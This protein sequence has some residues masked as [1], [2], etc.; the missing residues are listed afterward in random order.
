VDF[1]Y[2]NAGWF[3]SPLPRD[4]FLED[5]VSC[6]YPQE[7]AAASNHP[8]KKNGSSDS[9]MTKDGSPASTRCHGAHDLALLF[10]VLAFGMQLEAP[11]A[12]H[13]EDSEVYQTLSRAA[14][15]L[16]PITNGCSLSLI[17]TLELMIYRYDGVFCLVLLDA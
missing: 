10:L 13:S 14:L 16:E 6:F 15:S 3:Y 17:Q 7:Y 4:E 2:T 9:T 11:Y 8:A 12:T 1:F 5:I